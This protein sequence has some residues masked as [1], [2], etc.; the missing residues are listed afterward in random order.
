MKERP[1]L[2]PTTAGAVF[3]PATPRDSEPIARLHADSWRRHY[4][5]AFSD[6]YLDGDLIA[7]R[8]SVWTARLSQPEKGQFTV[9]AERSGRMVGFAHT[10]AGG[11]PT[12]GALLDNLHVSHVEK[13]QGIGI[14]LMAESARSL[15]EVDP[16]S[17]LYL[18]VLAQNVAAQGF[19]GARG[20]TCVERQ[21][22]H[23]DPGDRLRYAWADPS[24]LLR[25]D[26]V[27]LPPTADC[28]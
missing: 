27:P 9:V 14:G 3:R 23:P 21:S 2:D 16:S 13:G 8:L 25:T 1:V 4:R 6:D 19:Y 26:R 7:E 28:R 10:V 5:G 22:R 17:S 18:W 20:G 11:D 15:I 24:V 12:W